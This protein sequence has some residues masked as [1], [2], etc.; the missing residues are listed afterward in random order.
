MTH[1][2]GIE[3]WI[4]RG[5]SAPWLTCSRKSSFI[6]E[7]LLFKS[8]NL[9]PIQFLSVNVYLQARK[10]DTHMHSSQGCCALS[11]WREHSR[12]LQRVVS[13]RGAQAFRVAVLLSAQ[14]LCMAPADDVDFYGSSSRSIPVELSSG[15]FAIDCVHF[16]QFCCARLHLA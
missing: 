4:N 5:K 12:S 15:A 10:N 13:L 2:E 16:A 3:K 14:P 8:H 11:S 7:S 6:E 9:E 1:N